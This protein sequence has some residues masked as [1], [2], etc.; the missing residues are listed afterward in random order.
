MST[1]EN[2]SQIKGF[3]KVQAFY[4]NNRKNVIIVGVVLILAAAGLYYYSNIMLPQKEEAAQAELFKAQ[5]YFQQDSTEKALY[6][7]G[8]ALGFIDIADQYGS[9]KAGNLAHYYA[10]RLLMD[11]GEFDAA[12]EHLGKTSFSDYFFAASVVILQGDCHSELGDYSKAA[13]LYE[14]AAEGPSLR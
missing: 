6:G 3:D 7:D 2:L 4:T 10:G 8:Q 1:E 5:Q 11:K 12:L 14:D 13:G 9:T